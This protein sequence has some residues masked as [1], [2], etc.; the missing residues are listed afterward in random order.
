MI[1]AHVP[2]RDVGAQIES[3]LAGARRLESIIAGWQVSPPSTNTLQ[4]AAGA[5]E[6][7]RLTVAALRCQATPPRSAGRE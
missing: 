4:D 7:L 1:A 3:M 5:I 6:G 2:I